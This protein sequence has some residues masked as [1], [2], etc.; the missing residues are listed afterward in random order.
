MQGWG[1]SRPLSSQ[2]YINNTTKE[3]GRNT[4]D[5]VEVSGLGGGV[6]RVPRLEEHT[7]YT[8]LKTGPSSWVAP[9]DVGLAGAVAGGAGGGLSG[10][11]GA[12]P[13][14]VAGG[15]GGLSRATGVGGAVALAVAARPTTQVLK[16]P[17]T[18]DTR[19]RWMNSND[20]AYS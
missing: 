12:G 16:T 14:A 10:G 5:W 7:Y 15:A 20:G 6:V 4:R 9:T 8:N 19:A 2:N 3:A 1:E 17:A 11:A 18:R 13:G